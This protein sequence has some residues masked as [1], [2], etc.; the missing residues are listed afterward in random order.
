MFS[1]STMFIF[2]LLFPFHFH[3]FLSSFFNKIKCVFRASFHSHRV[4]YVH[5]GRV[6]V[7]VCLSRTATVPFRTFD[8]NELK[9]WSIDNNTKFLLNS[10]SQSSDE[11][12][13]DV[14]KQTEHNFDFARFCLLID[15]HH[16]ANTF[17][18]SQPLAG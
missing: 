18:Q 15:S 5:T 10:G 4:L 1:C 16:S 17:V 7:P 6:F 9:R 3:F 8:G 2:L 11:N 12:F 13:E 14:T